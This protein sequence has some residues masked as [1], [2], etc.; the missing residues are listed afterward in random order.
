MSDSSKITLQEKALDYHSQMPA[1]K[2]EVVPTK[3]AKTQNDLSLAYSPGVAAPCLEIAKNVEEAYKYTAKGNLVAVISNGSAVLGLGNIGA[4]AAK[5]VMEGKG[6]LFKIFAG[7]DVFD[8]EINEQDPNK[9]V[10]IV[11]SL[12][13]TFG[14]INLEDIKAPECFLIEKRLKA[15]MNIPV[16]HDDQHGTAIISGAALLNALELQN[17]K[18]EEAKFVVSGAGA[19]GISCCKLYLQLGARRENFMI[20]DSK[21]ILHKGRNLEDEKSFFAV[22]EDKADLSLTDAMKIADVFIG[23]SKGNLLS[24]EMIKSMPPRP[25]V[26]AM[27]NPDPEIS[28]PDAIE[29]RQDIIMATGRSDYPNQVNNVLGFPYIFR[30]ALDIRATAINNEMLLAAVYALAELVKKPVPEVVSDAYKDSNLTFG[31]SY[32]VPKPTDP[33][34]LAFT[35]K[36][37]AQAAIKS[38]VAQKEITDWEAYEASLDK[39]IGYHNHLARMLALKAKSYIRKVKL[40]F[41]DSEN[42]VVL[43]TAQQIF[44]EGIAEPILLGNKSV[45]EKLCVEN[46]L[47]ILDK[48]QIVDSELP[49][50]RMQRHDFAKILYEERC[51]KG[52]TL[53]GAK[54]LMHDKTYFGCMM[55]K[56]GW[57]D[58]MITGYKQDYKLAIQTALRT[59]GSQNE[60]KTLAGMHILFTKKGPLFF[61]DATIH[62]NPTA[63]E[64]AEITLLVCKNIRS[65]G[66]IPKVAMLSYSNFGDSAN[67]DEIN[68][69]NQAKKI[70]KEKSPDLV[71]DGEIQPHIALNQDLLKE[72][73][74]FSELVGHQVNTLIFPNMS[75]CNISINLLTETSRF[76]SLG[77]VILGLKQP[78]HILQ[79]GSHAG[80]I[81]NMALMA[82]NDILNKK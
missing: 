52:L 68:K 62:L 50:M 15:E 10:E 38:G 67:K 26:F 5:P 2:I 35:A 54:K 33:R 61:A 19:A 58:A 7:I 40:L 57:V 37:V 49:N 59:I 6:V 17:K 13:P 11:K 44:D 77:P 73:Y 47:N 63:Q 3:P 74:P 18:I 29:A 45:I 28:Y 23:L 43:K 53:V 41:E 51:R 66:I 46:H 16:M 31:P 48:I 14:A 8:I 32:I 4:D 39:K 75:A 42:L 20:F 60:T 9:F 30:G 72:N 36:A 82:V 79:P 25:I 24:K 78:I 12:E 21:G 64:L 22:D 55:V 70:V 34:L 56:T 81:Y 69:I 71:I 65:L 76:E 27:A 80:N 1:G